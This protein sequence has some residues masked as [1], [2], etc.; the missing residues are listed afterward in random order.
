M[1][2]SFEVVPPNAPAVPIVVH[3]PHA[4][5]AVPAD[6]RR[7]LLLDDHE[8]AEE[9][10]LI[11]DHR[12]D[13]LAADVAELGATRFVNRRSRLVVDP[14]RFPDPDLEVME[15][16]GMGAVYTATTARSPLRDGDPEER[17]RLLDRYFE[18]Y[19]RAFAELVTD[20][21]DD[22]GYC[23]IVDLHSYPSVRLPYELGGDERPEVCIGT[24]RSHTPS[25]LEGLVVEVASAHDLT[26]ATDTPFSGVYVPL[27]RYGRDERVT[28]VMLELRRDTY[29]DEAT[30]S[31]HEGEVRMRRFVRDVVAAI[32]RR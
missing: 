21:L 16:R 17:R 22:H 18:P 7:G 5:T 6:V 3:V 13:V 30:A 31:P 10:R 12:T 28:A 24:D 8:L 15:R 2:A 4:A 19:A 1:S 26:T 9:L 11:T 32:A 29:L 23:T 27:D 25:W 14:E 20:H